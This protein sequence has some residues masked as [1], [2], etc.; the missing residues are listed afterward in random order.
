MCKFCDLDKITALEQAIAN[1]DK[2]HTIRTGWET[3]DLDEEGKKTFKQLIAE[4][5]DLS[6]ET[7]NGNNRLFIDGSWWN[8][9]YKCREKSKGVPAFH[10]CPMC[11]RK[12]D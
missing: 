12:L 5:K 4:L 3:F 1:N 2:E 6:I 11:G 8:D 9:F 7:N 10:Y